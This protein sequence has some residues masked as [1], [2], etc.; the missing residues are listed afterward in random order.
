MKTTE[1]KAGLLLLSVKNYASEVASK[2][3]LVCLGEKTTEGKGV[4]A[5]SAEL[6][7]ALN[8]L[9]NSIAKERVVRY[10]EEQD[11]FS[12]RGRAHVGESTRRQRADSTVKARDAEK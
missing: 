10:A 3:R 5:H 1:R 8:N 2:D 9:A 7:L 6:R 11:V 12:Q 4:F